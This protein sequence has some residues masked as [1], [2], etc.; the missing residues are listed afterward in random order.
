VQ[1]LTEI[2]RLP[3]GCV[4]TYDFRRFLPQYT[5]CDSL[6]QYGDMGNVV[7]NGHT[8][9]VRWDMY[10]EMLVSVGATHI[11]IMPDMWPN[12]LKLQ[13]YAHDLVAG[14][15]QVED[16]AY[17]IFDSVF[18]TRYAG[19]STLMTDSTTKWVV[20]KIKSDANYTQVDTHLSTEDATFMDHSREAYASWAGYTDVPGVNC[21]S[22]AG[23]PRF[24]AIPGSQLCEI[25]EL[26]ADNF[27]RYTNDEGETEEFI[28][29][30]SMML[31]PAEQLAVFQEKGQCLLHM[32]G[33]QARHAEWHYHGY[34]PMMRQHDRMV[35]WPS[36][37]YE[38][39]KL[40]KVPGGENG[41]VAYAR[42][43]SVQEL[44]EAP[45]FCHAAELLNGWDSLED[46]A[47]DVSEAI[48][49]SLGI[50]A[51]AVG[52]SIARYSTTLATESHS[53]LETEMA[54][55]LGETTWD[56]L[57]GPSRLLR[58]QGDEVVSPVSDGLPGAFHRDA[59]IEAEMFGENCACDLL[60]SASFQRN[61]GMDFETNREVFQRFVVPVPCDNFD[62][63]LEFAVKKRW[64]SVTLRTVQAVLGHQGLGFLEGQGSLNIALRGE[65][66][67]FE[68][69]E[70][71]AMSLTYGAAIKNAGDSWFAASDTKLVSTVTRNSMAS[72][73]IVD[74]VETLSGIQINLYCGAKRAFGAAGGPMPSPYPS[75]EEWTSIPFRECLEN[76]YL[77]NARIR[78]EE[79]MKLYFP[80]EIV[81]VAV[82]EMLGAAECS[83]VSGQSS[84]DILCQGARASTTLDDHLEQSDM[85]MAGLVY[86]G[87][88]SGAALP[89]GIP[90][91]VI[92]RPEDVLE[93][94]SL[95]D[96]E[97]RLQDGEEAQAFQRAACSR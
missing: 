67:M 27:E 36:V 51:D 39:I 85:E 73:T 41:P 55:Q 46:M 58:S 77:T 92:L 79:P 34:D 62:P 68:E 31:P 65:G 49:G 9:T 12:A 48:I 30:R 11:Q 42:M 76:G 40:I 45:R 63:A 56:E 17:A 23:D 89:R 82:F 7:I 66:R 6:V 33:P 74:Q 47:S 5:V 20:C 53:R 50:G 70:S 8:L 60:H 72:S 81:V 4:G 59:R 26:H 16:R 90:R 64:A 80:D 87:I 32:T 69:P 84:N 10:Q 38:I 18:R 15:N 97:R 22:Q 2:I 75:D 52:Q 94:V 54:M 91:E 96:R 83:P 43:C 88:R 28:C 3:M 25:A 93:A 61:L 13:G 57:T 24:D 44:N 35:N 78:A 37:E 71:N 95:L 86:T 29:P 14:V 21:E 1:A 19:L